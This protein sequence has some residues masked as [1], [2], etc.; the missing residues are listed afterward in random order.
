[1]SHDLKSNLR[2]IYKELDISNNALL[3]KHEKIAYG[4]IY[5][6]SDQDV[7]AGDLFVFDVAENLHG[8]Q[9]PVPGD[10]TYTKIKV[11]KPGRYEIHYSINI[12]ASGS[13][14]SVA[15]NP[16]TSSP[17]SGPEQVVIQ[18]TNSTTGKTY[19]KTNSMFARANDI[20]PL[21]SHSII[22][23]NTQAPFNN[24]TIQ[25]LSIGSEIFTSARFLSE[26]P[27]LVLTGNIIPKVVDQPLFP[28]IPPM[29]SVSV[30]LFRL[31]DL[32]PTLVFMNQP[33][34]TRRKHVIKDGSD[35]PLSVALTDGADNI[36]TNFNGPI[37][38]YLNTNPTKDK[39][40]G[41]VTVHAKNGV[42]TFK[43]IHLDKVGN[44]Y[45]LVASTPGHNSAYTMLFN[46]I[47]LELKFVCQPTDSTI[48][49]ALNPGNCIPGYQG[50][51]IVD[52]VVVDNNGLVY[53][54]SG[55]NIEYTIS[56][57]SPGGTNLF[58]GTSSKLIVPTDAIGQ[59]PLSGTINTSGT[60]QITA[61]GHEIE[62]VTSQTFIVYPPS[63]S[64]TTQPPSTV[65]HATVMSAITVEFFDNTDNTLDTGPFATAPI[66]V[67]LSPS[68][69]LLS[70][71]LVQVAAGGAATFADLQISL[72]GTY[73][74]VF[75]SPGATSATSTSITVT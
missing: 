65:V 6:L 31:G 35:L 16:K 8:V 48:T 24:D 9:F 33:A 17:G 52:V 29:P 73:Q 22:G 74:L 58:N 27:S 13:T 43:H 10:A 36:M 50:R 69:S 25:L 67:Y 38:I 62:S 11:L 55:L 44:G 68:P 40:H 26:I 12:S 61:R 71:T 34:Q 51:D 54:H 19:V 20:Q 46:V 53:A 5:S 59:A 1:M 49:E 4:N 21:S 2:P 37:T 18:V 70:G 66:T 72:P 64:I 45:S 42:A 15:T 57:F 7:V 14:P 41:H 30:S 32:I 39:L 60:Y 47:R 28:V 56:S 75:T 63:L 23:L 3:E